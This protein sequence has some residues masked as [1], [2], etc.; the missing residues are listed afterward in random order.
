MARVTHSGRVRRA[1]MR[2]TSTLLLAAQLATLGH[3]LIVRHTICPEHGE[4]I[5]AASPSEAQ[6]LRASPAGLASGPALDRGATPAEHADDHCLARANT[7][8]RFALLPTPDVTPGSL[9]ETATLPSLSTVAVA[10]AVAV[11]F[12]APKNSPPSA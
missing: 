4:A 6:A 12:L 8:E 5:H 3:L 1:R 7:R 10:P 11:L 9:L 2:A